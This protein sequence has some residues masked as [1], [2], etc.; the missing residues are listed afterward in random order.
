MANSVKANRFNIKRIVYA[1]VLKDDATAYEHGPIKTF[2]APMTAQFTPSYANGILYGGGVKTED[3]TKLTGGAL[4]VEVNK[5]PIEVRA[6]IYGHTYEDGILKVNKDD[7]A[8]D[9]AIG[10]EIEQTGGKSEFTW[11]FKCKAKPLGKNAQQSTENMNYSTDSMDIAVMARENNGDFHYDADTANPDFTAEMAAT[12][13]NTI[14]GGE[15]VA[16]GA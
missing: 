4:K 6:D 1:K 14:P 12:F 16:E 7:Q 10:Y 9:I 8:K 5:I 13:L 11:L 3:T 15:L 2:G